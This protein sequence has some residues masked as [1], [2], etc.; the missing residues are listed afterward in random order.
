MI[1]K[2]EKPYLFDL[3]EDPNEVVNFYND[4]K[5]TDIAKK[6]QTELFKQL[7]KYDEPGLKLKQEYIIR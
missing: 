7:K 4:K 6:M 2:K 3:Q 5:Y 1:D